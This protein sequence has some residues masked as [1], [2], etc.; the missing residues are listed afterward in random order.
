M[1]DLMGRGRDGE[2]PVGVF[3]MF[4]VL[5]RCPAERSG[6][7]LEN[8]PD[9]PI[10]RWCHSDIAEPHANGLP[11]AKRSCGHYDIDAFIQKARGVSNRVFESDYLCLEPRA[12]GA[13]F[14]DFSEARHVTDSA[15]YNQGLP[16]HVA[17]DG[18]VHCAAVWFQC[19]QSR[20]R[21][22]VEV[23]VFGDYYEEHAEAGA[24]ANAQKVKDLTADY[25]GLAVTAGT[26][27]MDP[28][29]RQ[30]TGVGVT[31]V[32]EFKR[33]GCVG[34]PVPTIR[35]W[36][37]LGQ[38]RPKA[39]SLGLLE[40]LLLSADGVVSIKIHP[41]CRHLIAALKGYLRARSPDG[42]FLDRPMDPQHP[43]EDPIDALCGG[44]GLELP[45]GRTPRDTSMRDVKAGR[46]I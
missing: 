41:R 40:A 25:T 2:F 27:S 3:C 36:P 31:V 6:A 18:G 1:A 34:R 30:S 32:G 5:E 21:S 39:D 38:G 46:I 12:E 11:K 43:A 24:S 7:R 10:V 14:T 45:Q 22:H 20:D 8:C 42:Q 19:R 26:V 35:E 23:N 37:H 15:E 33:M 29:G 9:C 44:L 16:F 17:I 13:W 28:A 4:D